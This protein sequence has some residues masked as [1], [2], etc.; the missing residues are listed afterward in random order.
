M[1][2]HVPPK[3]DLQVIQS[4]FLVAAMGPTARSFIPP[5]E[6]PGFKLGRKL[7]DSPSTQIEW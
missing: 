7:E 6:L 3:G 1:S 2:P 4:T 5:S